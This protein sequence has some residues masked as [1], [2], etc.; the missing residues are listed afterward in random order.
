M[1]LL[2]LIRPR[3]RLGSDPLVGGTVLRLPEAQL[4][5][6]PGLWWRALQEG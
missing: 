4:K 3:D 6:E 2:L 1:M 5:H